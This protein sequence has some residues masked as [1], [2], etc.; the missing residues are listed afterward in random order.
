MRDRRARDARRRLVFIVMTLITISASYGAGGSEIGPELAKRLGVPFLDRNIPVAV[1]ERLAVPLAQAL[2]HDQSV[3]SVLDRLLA[4]F[5][6]A[7]GY[8][9]VAGYGVP[10]VVDTVAEKSYAQTTEQV[11]QE[12]AADGAAIILG[13]AGSVVLKEDPRALHVRLDG[14]TEQRVV[15]AM[16]IQDVDRETAE[17]RMRETDRAREAYVRHFYNTDVHDP[18]L[19]QLMI[20]STAVQL[21]ACVEIIDL[22]AR[23]HT[24]SP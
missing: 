2:D 22:A 13:R 17:R 16:R 4:G 6:G 15:Q 8:A 9:G 11:I 12:H 21:D 20:D 18:H 14:P 23:S 3:S 1:A 19:Y 7:A 10:A 24:R 5:A